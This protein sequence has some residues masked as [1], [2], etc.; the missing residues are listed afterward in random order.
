[1]TAAVIQNRPD[2]YVVGGTMRLDAPSYVARRADEELYDALQRREF[3]Y[4][5]T[6]RQMGKSSL[7]IRTAARLRATG[8]NVAVLDLTAIGQNLSAEQWYGGLLVQMGQRLEMED[9]LLEFWLAQ[10]SLGPLQRWLQALRSIVLPRQ[11][12]PL[13]IFI[14]EI[15]AVR[16]LP[17]AADE[18]FA[19]IRDCYNQRST[20]PQMQGLTFCLSGVAAPS[21]L[22]RDTRTT[23]F[24]IGRRI[25]LH[26]FTVA[27]AASLTDGLARAPQ[28]GQ[29]LLRRILYWTN[30]HP[31]LTQRLCQATASQAGVQNTSDID[32]LCSEMFFV[33]RVRESDDNLLFV[34]ERLLRSEVD[35][36]S[37]LELYSRVRR[38]KSVMDD[39]ADPLV[40]VLRLSGV[41]RT[42]GGRL[43]VRNRI[44]AHVFDRTWATANL[45]DAER[46]RQRAAFQRGVW[47]TAAVST[48]FLALVSWLAFVAIQQRNRA[49]RQAE[50]NRRLLEY[51]Q[52]RAA[53]EAAPQQ[54]E[55]LLAAAKYNKQWELVLRSW[56]QSNASRAEELLGGM[57][58]P[59]GAPDV[60]G[61]EW[62]WLWHL[63]HSEIVRLHLDS[64]VAG[65]TLLP[66]G[67]T[68]AIG[69]SLRTKGEEEYLITL[70]DTAAQCEVSSFRSPA[71]S[72][73]NLVSFSPDQ[74]QV[75]VDGPGGEIKLWDLQSGRLKSVFVG[76]KQ[77]ITVIAFSGDGKRI[78]AGDLNGIA[79]VW[80]TATGARRLTLRPSANWVRGVVFSPDG[81]WLAT[82]DESRMVRLWDAMTGRAVAPITIAEGAL[83]RAAFSP[84]GQRLVTTARDGRL[85]IWET[86]TRHLLDSLVGHAS[87]ANAMVFSPDG[88]MLATGSADR[89]TRLWDVAT[90]RA[91]ALIRGHGSGVS[92]LAWSQDSQRLVTGGSD[93]LV[94]IWAAIPREPVSPAEPVT[95]YLASAFLA[96]HNLIAFGVTRDRTN[97]W[98]LSSGQVLANFDQ[99]S[100]KLL[101]ATFSPD[102]KLLATGDLDQLIK[103]WDTATGR[104][105][106]VLRGHQGYVYSVDFAP[107]G[108]L[109]VSG[110]AD[111][112]LR[113]WDLGAG[114]ELGQLL[115]GVENYYRAVFAP[116][117]RTI[118]SACPDGSLK[119]WDVARRQLIK[120]FTVNKHTGRVRAIAFSRDGRWLVSGGE[121]N[122][123]RLWDVSTGQMLQNLGQSDSIRRAAF[124]ADGKRLVTG[125]TDG[126]VKLW[127]LTTFQ[128]LMIL[129]GHASHI[130]SVT[131]SADGNDLSTSSED[132]TIRLWRGD[133]SEKQ[134][135]EQPLNQKCRIPDAKP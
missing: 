54:V 64:A 120:T 114:N 126:A 74:R 100:E 76:E 124:S 112:T 12:G 48:A 23:P 88:R 18:L 71:G 102:G 125:G 55:E 99:T 131:F 122:T 86:R 27:E 53:S 58:P 16:S 7:M 130:S 67:K 32:R 109:L 84:D 106:H 17:F 101:C 104:L 121:D 128:E 82:T 98:N 60:R 115:G 22:I 44:Y 42:E 31:Y 69:R 89:T 85:H 63:T 30:G 95:K 6:A 65:L 129:P 66:G 13:V 81:R 49:E 105:L 1:M 68:L 61:P 110:S 87:E 72:N 3:C 46:Q 133:A 97:L 35:V 28:Q 70:Y 134:L 111:R 5:L 119:L 73:F 118:A 113:L 4:V 91:L 78:A 20:I 29:A 38:H 96:N 50:I 36:S 83:V 40:S 14:D 92:C 103:L 80:D 10:T 33:Q 116:D 15:D 57:V 62:Y 132:G 26:D 90:G 43:R 45:P 59:P 24:N 8:I 77:A 19:G 37:L 41:T 34:R 93:G 135:S 127:D 117:G 79:M 75:A 39:E 51:R 56:E 11:S 2:F 9:D 21:D 123:V 94:K 52:L 25:E 108:K 107:D 47:R